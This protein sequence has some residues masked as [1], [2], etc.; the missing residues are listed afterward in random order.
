[1]SDL[2][3]LGLNWRQKLEVL[4][5]L[6]RPA[7]SQ[8]LSAGHIP[9]S[10]S[11]SGSS[12]PTN[13][14]SPLLRPRKLANKDFV[15]LKIVNKRE[16]STMPEYWDLYGYN[17]ILNPTISAEER[18]EKYLTEMRRVESPDKYDRSSSKF[19]PELP[20]SNNM[21]TNMGQTDSKYADVGSKG[22]G[23]RILPRIV[24]PRD[25]DQSITAPNKLTV[26]LSLD[27][28][29]SHNAVPKGAY[30]AR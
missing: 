21:K 7:K 1:M 10:N 29:T 30:S 14:P 22:G 9:H 19:L 16:Q 6:P 13:A 24:K 12:T 5:R 25:Q 15:K 28:E 17:D 20:Q 4:K 27:S 2:D 3:P 8:T 11:S 23:W 26:S 18:F